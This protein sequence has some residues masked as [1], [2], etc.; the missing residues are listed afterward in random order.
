LLLNGNEYGNKALDCFEFPF[1][2]VNSYNALLVNVDTEINTKIKTLLSD[3][4]TITSFN[5]NL[6]S[7][8]CLPPNWEWKVVVNLNM[9]VYPVGNGH[10]GLNTSSNYISITDQSASN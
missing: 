2:C 4:T 1:K 5:V 9:K 3:F 7:R 8:T 6:S 10:Y